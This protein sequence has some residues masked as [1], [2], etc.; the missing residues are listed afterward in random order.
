MLWPSVGNRA[1]E[2]NNQTVSREGGPKGV[3]SDV[4]GC[5]D[6]IREETNV[7]ER[8]KGSDGRKAVGSHSKG[9]GPLLGTQRVRVLTDGAAVSTEPI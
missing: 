1:D 6:L 5:R 9:E 4:K 2:G 3:T 8:Q 7:E